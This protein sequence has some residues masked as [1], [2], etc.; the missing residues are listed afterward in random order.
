LRA[1]AVAAV[2]L[3][4]AFPDSFQGAFTGVDIFFVISGFLISGII[5]DELRDG[6][7]TFAR[8]YARRVRRIFPALALVLA[9]TVLLGWLVLTPYDFNQLG[10][11][12]AAG[13]GFLSNILLWQQSGY[14]D[15]DS[16]LKPLLHLWSLGIE[17]QYYLL[18]PLLLF[19]FRHHMHRILWLILAIAAVSFLLNVMMVDRWPSATF[20][21]PITR[22]WELMFG[23][24]L[25]YLHVHRTEGMRMRPALSNASAA[26]GAVLLVL[27]FTLINEGREFPGWWALLPTLG[28]LML[29]SA[30]PEAWINRRLLSNRAVVYI[31]LISY[32]LYLWHWPLL[33]FTK[34][35]NN[36]ELPSLELRLAILAATGLLAWAT[37]E[38]I[39][40]PV[41]RLGRSPAAPRATGAIATAVGGL[42]ILGLLAAANYATA[43]SNSLPYLAEISAAYTDWHVHARDT[44][45]GTL[46][47]TVLFL[48]DSHMQQ[49]WPRIEALAHGATPHHAVIFRTRGGCAPVPGIERPGYGCKQFVDEVFALARRPEI[50]TVVIGASWVGFTA[51]KDYYRVDDHDRRALDL[52]GADQQW[53]LQ[54][55]QREVANLVASGKQVIVVLSSVYGE[56]FDPRAMARRDGLGFDV[57]LPSPISRQVV[58]S[59]SAYIDDVIKDIARQTHAIVIDPRD[60]ICSATACPTLDAQG[61]PILKDDSHLRSSFVSAHFDAFDSYVLGSRPVSASNGLAKVRSIK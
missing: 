12:V 39:E 61:K 37:Y 21:L 40:K 53:A 8:F 25:A 44:F 22:I 52:H 50:Q 30:G 56:E 54:G 58:D 26:I 5:L 34:I 14:F 33:V 49:F 38:L 55:F 10:A 43:R 46:P 41:R 4:H 42:G 36:G 29:I 45:P 51:R 35:L 59:D 19:V 11:H 31:G 9:V 20:Y 13:A 24:I 3:F 2:L 47:G 17:E 18:W 15:T 57:H 27:A 16:A 6:T 32:P 1:V 28:T 48:G 7:F 23:S 60:T